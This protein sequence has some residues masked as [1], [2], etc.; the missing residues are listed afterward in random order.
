VFRSALALSR[1]IHG[2]LAKMSLP[3][4]EVPQ[5]ARAVVGRCLREHYNTEDRSGSSTYS[6]PGPQAP[7]KGTLSGPG[8]TMMSVE[9]PEI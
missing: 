5:V 6:P 1:G 9:G 7:I 8:E 3:G 4:G 2:P